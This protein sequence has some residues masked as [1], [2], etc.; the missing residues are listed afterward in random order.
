M[1]ALLSYQPYYY[2]YFVSIT[3]SDAAVQVFM[4]VFQRHNQL[5]RAR[6][7]CLRG[8]VLSQVIA[9]R[10]YSRV[11]C[12]WGKADVVSRC[13]QQTEVP[14]MHMAICCHLWSLVLVQGVL[15][16]SLVNLCCSKQ[17]VWRACLVCDV[18]RLHKHS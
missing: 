2:W 10:V 8:L 11:I 13:T 18:P 14:C 15:P 4:L 12:Q 7:C 1:K 5:L 17:F 6:C 3:A 9:S 16:C